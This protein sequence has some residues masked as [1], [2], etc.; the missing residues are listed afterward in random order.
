[1]FDWDDLRYFLAVAHAA[2]TTAAAKALG[3]NQSTVQR[4]L[5]MLEE[6]IGHKLIERHPTG[7]QLSEIGKELLPCAEDVE[8]AVTAFERRLVSSGQSLTGVVRVTC[9]DGLV[10]ALIIP[11]VNDFYKR[12][13][14]ITVDLI[15]T[16]R[17]LDLS[18][19]EADIAVRGGVPGPDVLFGRKIAEVPGRSMRAAPT[20]S[21]MAGPNGRKTSI[22]MR[23][24]ISIAVTRTPII[25]PTG[26]A[27]SRRRQEL[28]RA[29]RP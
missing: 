27:P 5:A 28:Q 11:L 20:S 15:V 26:C 23:S 18:K 22:V 9:P 14:G 21:A 19:G 25:S 1:M 17:F 16:E 3:V 24:S 6:R 7:C 8:R 29:A 4:R 2:S 12:Y 13:P 10:T